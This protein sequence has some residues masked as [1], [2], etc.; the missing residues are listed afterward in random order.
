MHIEFTPSTKIIAANLSL[1]DHDA[2]RVTF[3]TD[4]F[5]SL[6]VD[7]R[8]VHLLALFSGLFEE[9]EIRERLHLNGCDG[10][11]EGMNEQGLLTQ[12]EKLSFWES[13]IYSSSVNDRFSAFSVYVTEYT[14]VIL[15][16]CVL[17][18]IYH[19]KEVNLLNDYIISADDV[20]QS[21][22]FADKD[23]G[24]KLSS[25]LKERYNQKCNV[26]PEYTEIDAP[27]S[28]VLAKNVLAV[29]HYES[30]LAFCSDDYSYT[31]NLCE[32]Q[33]F[34]IPE[35]KLFA[36]SKTLQT[37]FQMQN[38]VVFSVLNGVYE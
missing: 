4:S 38:D 15:D 11:M 13:P 17:L 29:K 18:S 32:R 31:M 2:K 3:S 30:A 22:F 10:L 1:T 35:N 28:L 20:Y 12:S 27:T 14:P 26:F 25:I 8:C 9:R 5:Q 7:S 37:A 36:A 33:L 16:V 19:L 21:V 34:S 6:V 24:L 23:V